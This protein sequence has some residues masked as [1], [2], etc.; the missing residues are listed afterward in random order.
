[1]ANA[2]ARLVRIE[3]NRRTIPCIGCEN[4]KKTKKKKTNCSPKV[5]KFHSQFPSARSHNIHQR[6]Y[7]WFACVPRPVQNGRY[8]LDTSF[9][10]FTS[11]LHYTVCCII[12]DLCTR[13]KSV[14]PAVGLGSILFRRGAACRDAVLLCVCTGP[15]VVEVQLKC[16]TALV[17]K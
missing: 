7:I 1:M 16:K 11:S 3:I 15:S 8:G 10:L 2:Q 5:R 4:R 14:R 6:K 13:G 12:C 17:T 9:F